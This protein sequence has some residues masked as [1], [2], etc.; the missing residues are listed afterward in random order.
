MEEKDFGQLK[1]LAHRLTAKDGLKKPSQ[2][3][4]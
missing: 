2:L 4:S 1:M 3:Q